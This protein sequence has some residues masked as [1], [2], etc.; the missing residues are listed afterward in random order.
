[1]LPGISCRKTTLCSEKEMVG[2]CGK[3]EM[4]IAVGVPRCSWRR[5]RSD[6]PADFADWTRSGM[7]CFPRLSRTAVG[8]S[9]LIS[10]A[11][12]ESLEEGSLEVVTS[13]RGS[14]MPDSCAYSSSRSS[15]SFVVRSPA[16]SSYWKSFLRDLSFA[17]A[18]SSGLPEARAA[19]SFA[20]FSLISA[21]RSRSAR[22]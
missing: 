1:M 18:G 17:M 9:N 4:V 19:L 21:S 8:K 13:T 14:T 15:C 11:K 20:R 3:W 16:D 6:K 10:L 5:I 12:D 2:P 7:I 22:L